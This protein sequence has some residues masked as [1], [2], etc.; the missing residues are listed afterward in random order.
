MIYKKIYLVKGDPF[1]ISVATYNR[2]AGELNIRNNCKENL[3]LTKNLVRNNIKTLKRIT[4][5]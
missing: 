5:S 2:H 1:V 3:F 4:S